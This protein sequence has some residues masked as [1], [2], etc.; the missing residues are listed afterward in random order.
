MRIESWE[1]ESEKKRK[2]MEATESRQIKPNSFLI[3]CLLLYGKRAC[4]KQTAIENTK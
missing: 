4:T 1:Q 3:F 2:K